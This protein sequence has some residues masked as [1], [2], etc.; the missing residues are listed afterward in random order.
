MISVKEATENA[1]LFNAFK[2]LDTN[3]DGQLDASEVAKYVPSKEETKVK[4]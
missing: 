3:K 2:S 1:E 4:G